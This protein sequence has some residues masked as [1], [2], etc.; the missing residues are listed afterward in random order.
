MEPMKEKETL[1]SALGASIG[2][3]EHRGL[4]GT[5]G[6]FSD[7]GLLLHDPDGR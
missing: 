1:I 5:L 4:Q 2:P 7:F 3:A 6:S